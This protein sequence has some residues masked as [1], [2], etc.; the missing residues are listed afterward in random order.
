MPMSSVPIDGACEALVAGEQLWLLPQRVAYWPARRTLLVA[1]AHLGKAGAFRRLGVPVPA[2]TTQDDLRTLS[3]LID[4][5]GAERL[6]FLGDLVHSRTAVEAAAPAVTAWRRRHAG[7]HMLLVVGNHDRHAG[8]LPEAWGVE[9]V[10]EPHVVHS[11]A[12]V[13]APRTIP[14]AFAICGHVHPG[15]R[16]VGRGR[17]RVRVPCFVLTRAFAVLP[18]FGAFTG[19]QEIQPQEGWRI[20]A[21]AG[22]RVVPLG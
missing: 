16:L 18:A 11:L 2:G 8:A 6:V 10:E 14:G 17:Q 12:F 22:G 21:V 7:V 9:S 15:V 4:G 13:H 1:D 19:L 20:H 5:L 3:G